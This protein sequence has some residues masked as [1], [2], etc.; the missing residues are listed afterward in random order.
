MTEPN[1]IIEAKEFE[2]PFCGALKTIQTKDVVASGDYESGFGM[3]CWT[4]GICGSDND[5]LDEFDFT[6]MKSLPTER[7]LK[8]DDSD[9]LDLFTFAQYLVQ[10]KEFEKSAAIMRHIL[11]QDKDYH[12]CKYLM[13]KIGKILDLKKLTTCA[14]EISEVMYA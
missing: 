2:C 9:T 5:I 4:C 13:E 7:L 10:K 6:D 1:S 3:D 12:E 8:M 14:I 11:S